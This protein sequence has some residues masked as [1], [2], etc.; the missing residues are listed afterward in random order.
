VLPRRIRAAGFF[1]EN[2]MKKLWI[3]AVLLMTLI[4]PAIA[5]TPRTV[6]LM[7]KNGEQIGTA[8]FTGNR[9]FL[10][11]IKGELFAQI[12]VDADGTRTML[13]PNGKVLD[14]IKPSR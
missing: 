1:Q 10:R 8:T 13:D 9:I 6:P 11:D 5:Q 2:N 14:Q 4:M 7:G 12:V 3:V